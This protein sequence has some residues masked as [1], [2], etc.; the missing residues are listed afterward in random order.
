MNNCAIKIKDCNDCIH[1][2]I[3][4]DELCNECIQMGVW[5]DNFELKEEL[6]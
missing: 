1:S 6:K 3:Y 5:T 2:D 4:P